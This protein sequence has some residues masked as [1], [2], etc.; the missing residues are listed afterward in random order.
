ME[1]LSTILHRHWPA[2]AFN[3]DTK[4]ILAGHSN[5]GQGV[6]H[7]A[8]HYPDRVRGAIAAAGFMNAQAYVS[9]GLS[10]GSRFVG[11]LLRAILESAYTSDNNELFLGNIA[12]TVPILA[13]HG[14]VAPISVY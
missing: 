11:P 13:M 4:V 2:W 7:L 12:H 1:A 5:G 10:H 14:C 8:V 3:P 6:W 9:T